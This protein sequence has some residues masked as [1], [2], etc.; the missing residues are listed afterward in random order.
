VIGEVGTKL[1]RAGVNIAEY[2]QARREAGGEALGVVTVDGEVPVEVL[3]ELRAL[4]AVEE[5]RQVVFD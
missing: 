5:V 4:P 1:G 3:E 2:H